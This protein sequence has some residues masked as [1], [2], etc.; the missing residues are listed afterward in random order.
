MA[1]RLQ[2]AQELPQRISL[3]LI[4]FRRVGWRRSCAHSG[5]RHLLF[6]PASP[7][8]LARLSATLEEEA[9][10]VTPTCA[11]GAIEFLSASRYDAIVISEPL[12]QGPNRSHTTEV[13][14]L[15]KRQEIPVLVFPDSQNPSCKSLEQLTP[16]PTPKHWGRSESLGGREHLDRLFDEVIRPSFQARGGDIEIIDVIGEQVILRFLGICAACPSARNQHREEIEKFLRSEHPSVKYV[17]IEQNG[18][19]PGRWW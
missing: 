3:S 7:E 4:R 6:L 13:V 5:V 10:E 14:E 11:H 8:D 15:A 16:F 1:A 18:F 9:Y 17:V 12:Y 2:H 19:P